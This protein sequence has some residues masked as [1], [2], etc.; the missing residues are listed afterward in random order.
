MISNRHLPAWAHR[1]A[2]AVLGFLGSASTG[3][4]GYASARSGTFLEEASGWLLLLSPIVGLVCAALDP[5][6]FSL[7]EG[8]AGEAGND[9][10]SERLDS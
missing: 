10:L 6:R 2:N 8:T 4:G 7:V 1:A 9:E 5:Q 3:A